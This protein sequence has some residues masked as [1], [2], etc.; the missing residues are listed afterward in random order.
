MNMPENPPTRVSGEPAEAERKRPP[1]ALVAGGALLVGLLLG[2]A[3]F[4][5]GGEDTAA[6]AT[7]AVERTTTTVRRTTTTTMST[8]TTTTVP[9][10]TTTAAPVFGSRSNPHPLGST[11]VSSD[12]GTETW[13]VKVSEVVWDGWPA[14]QAENMFND[15]PAP[16]RQ[17]VLVRLDAMYVGSEE[18]TNFSRDFNVKG[19]DSSNVATDGSGCGVLPQSL[20]QYQDVYKDGM[21]GGFVCLD[22]EAARADSLVLVLEYGWDASTFLA[23]R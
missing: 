4:G 8:T 23:L 19:L 15:P 3:L 11:V 17:F 20:D 6:P 21:I 14:I 9:T 7:S 5:G 16:G 18:P 12:A 10:T 1:T 2:A 13:H 22:V